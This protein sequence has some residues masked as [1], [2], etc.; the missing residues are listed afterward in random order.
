MCKRARR[1]KPHPEQGQNSK[2]QN[3]VYLK[4]DENKIKYHRNRCSGEFIVENDMQSCRKH[5]K[6]INTFKIIHFILSE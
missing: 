1:I 4:I 6:L 5:C 2:G 3:N